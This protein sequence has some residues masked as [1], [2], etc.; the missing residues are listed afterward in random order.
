V[1]TVH[2]EERLSVEEFE[3]YCLPP[4]EPLYICRKPVS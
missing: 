1:E 3:G 4:G 2:M